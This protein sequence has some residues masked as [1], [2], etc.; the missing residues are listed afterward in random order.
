[1]VRVDVT[2]LYA[3]LYKNESSS[4]AVNTGNFLK[5]TRL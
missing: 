3:W 5:A 1:M 2:T 4:E